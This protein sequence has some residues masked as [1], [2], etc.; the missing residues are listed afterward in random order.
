MSRRRKIRSLVSGLL[1]QIGL[2]RLHF[3]GAFVIFALTVL[4]PPW[5]K[6]KCQRKDLLYYSGY[7]KDSEPTFVGYDFFFAGPK[8]ESPEPPVGTTPGETFVVTEYRIFWTV[9]LAEWVVI[10]LAA[11]ILFIVFSQR[12]RGSLARSGAVP[13]ATAE[14]PQA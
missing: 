9:L 7:V 1:N 11:C 5:L 10:V 13:S 8:W 4:P 6:V 12:Q 2:A 3:W 14:R